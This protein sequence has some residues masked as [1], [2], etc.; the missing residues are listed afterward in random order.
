MIPVLYL[1]VCLA[2][3]VAVGAEAATVG[4]VLAPLVAAAA[5]A[6]GAAWLSVVRRRSLVAMMARLRDATPEMA[7]GIAAAPPGVDRIIGELRVLGF[8]PIGAIDTRIGEGEPI[9]T[10]I[11]AGE[12][13]TTWVEVGATGTGMAV[14]LSQGST[15]RFLETTSRGGEDIDRPP[16]FARSIPDGLAK[17]AA[18]HRAT[19]D[20]WVRA[21]GPARLVRT[22][23]DYL[24]A[25][26]EQRRRTAGMRIAAHLDRVVTP[27]IRTWT[28]SALIAGASAIVVLVLPAIRG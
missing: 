1:V 20:E 15:G 28:T 22:M 8:D 24:E 10:W 14:F 5:I 6:A 9:R 3:V 16:L 26:A 12:P 27:G 13:W 23:D 4:D 2:A 19:L 21:S 17:V 25:E 7:A 11:L 18:T